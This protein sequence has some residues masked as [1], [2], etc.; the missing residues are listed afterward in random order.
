MQKRKVFV[1]RNEYQFVYCIEGRRIDWWT[2]QGDYI[3]RSGMSAPS[4]QEV[5]EWWIKE[6]RTF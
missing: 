4:I 3:G 5:L 2:S 6:Y 1:Y